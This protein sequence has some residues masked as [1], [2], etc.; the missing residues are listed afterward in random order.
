MKS[1]FDPLECGEKA[2]KPL[3]LPRLGRLMSKLHFLFFLILQ[4]QGVEPVI[5]DRAEQSGDPGSETLAA[6]NGEDSHRGRS[7]RLPKTHDNALPGLPGSL[8]D[9]H[10]RHIP[11]KS[12]F[13]VEHIFLIGRS[14]KPDRVP[15]MPDFNPGSI[16]VSI[17]RCPAS[18]RMLKLNVHERLPRSIL[19]LLPRQPVQGLPPVRRPITVI[20]TNLPYHFS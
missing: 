6:F 18:V 2:K 13:R 20:P 9:M 1:R 12:G 5:L 14:Y 11:G 19:P 8:I 17:T 15:R 3:A 16:T 10:G 7:V 4:E